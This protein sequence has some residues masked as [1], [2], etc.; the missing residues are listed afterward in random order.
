MYVY[1]DKN[2]MVGQTFSRLTILERISKNGRGH[3]KCKCE[4]GNEIIVRSDGV[5]SGRIKSCGCYNKDKA[6]TGNA[7]RVHGKHGTRL[8]RIWQAMHARCYIKTNPAYKN[9][10]ARGITICAEWLKN[11]QAFYNWAMSNGYNDNLT[12]DRIDV[13]GNYEPN[14]C[15]WSTRKE[16][17]NNKRTNHYITFNNETHTIN[18]WA[19]KLKIDRHSISW[20]LKHNWTIEKTLTTPVKTRL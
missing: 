6:K 11:Y 7:R 16:Q 3:F 8:Y 17:A 5:L 18:E 20:R 1:K 4:C 19:E 2:N 9:Y 12:I 15:R 13:N 14:N 10:G